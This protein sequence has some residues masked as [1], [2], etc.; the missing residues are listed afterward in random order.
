MDYAEARIYISPGISEIQ[1][2]IETVDG[3]NAH[4]TSHFSQ[5][6]DFFIKLNESIKIPPLPIH[7]NV[8][9]K[10][11]SGTYIEAV[12]RI[13]LQLSPI[14]GAIFPGL[15]YFFDPRDHLRPSFYKLY[16]IGSQEYIYLLK[17]DLT[18]HPSY[19]SIITPG[20]NDTSPEYS[21]NHLPIEAD[22]IPLNT[23]D[24]SSTG[25]ATLRI[26]Q[27]VSETWIGET[28]R[29]YFVQG[30]WLDRE[31][32]KFF[33][34]LFTP[35]DSRLYP[36]YPFT[37]K[38]RAIC[39]SVAL[40]DPAGRKNLLGLAHHGRQFIL[41]HIQT[42]EDSLRSN[43]FTETLPSF[44]TLKRK[45]PGEWMNQLK[46]FKVSRYLNQNEM[47]EYELHYEGR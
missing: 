6:E 5:N 7:H 28:G 2:L 26:S 24:T 21:T 25:F 23:I 33:S 11:P 19:H 10:T 3:N 22:F 41:N 43:E 27:S 32:S 14:A 4:Y 30:I 37:C 47:R 36:Y 42:I 1:K 44:T 18:F 31:L 46:G 29:G 20:S 13:I 9:T 8:G 35:P 12:R 38:Y 34:K 17:L 16:R 15:N 39:H 45:V 40:L